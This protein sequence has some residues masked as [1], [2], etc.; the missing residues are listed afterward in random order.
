[1]HVAGPGGGHVK[2]S[3]V[4]QRDQGPGR[5]GRNPNTAARPGG[6]ADCD[7][8]QGPHASVEPAFGYMEHTTPTVPALGCWTA[9]APDHPPLLK[10]APVV[11]F[12]RAWDDDNEII[13]SLI[14]Q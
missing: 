6:S 7:P 10:G 14:I 12:H 11:A 1:M 3:R 9:L 4:V 5:L 2:P 13:S 8:I